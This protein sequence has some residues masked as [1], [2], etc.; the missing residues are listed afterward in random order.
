MAHIAVRL[1]PVEGL[2]CE[3]AVIGALHRSP[4]FELIEHN[5]AWLAV[6]STEATP[7]VTLAAVRAVALLVLKAALLVD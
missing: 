3:R 6:R 2:R 1:D 7:P 4:G 5:F